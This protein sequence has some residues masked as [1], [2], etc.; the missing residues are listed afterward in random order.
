MPATKIPWD[1]I[2]PAGVLVIVILILVFAF[3]L[4]S[5]ALKAPGPGPPKDVNTVN[6]KTL[7]FKHEGEIAGN[8]ATIVAFKEEMAKFQTTNGKAHEKIFGKFDD[9]GKE[10]TT[11][12]VDII[13]AIKANS[14]NPG[15]A[16]GS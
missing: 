7:C 9:L 6:K 12:K 1:I 13:K 15:S 4:R 11:V 16:P 8:T 14:K 5:Q 10:I 2:G 3:I